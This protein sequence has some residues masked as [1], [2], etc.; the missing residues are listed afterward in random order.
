MIRI[1]SLITLVIVLIIH[2]LTPDWI[3]TDFVVLGDWLA[4]FILLINTVIA[5]FSADI[6]KPKHILL[7]DILSF[8]FVVTVVRQGEE[9]STISFRIFRILNLDSFF[10]K[11]Y[12]GTIEIFNLISLL[13]LLIAEVI[14][15]IKAVRHYFKNPSAAGQEGGSL[16]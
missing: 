6:I 5:F 4:I 8:F 10:L 14:I 13:I 12:A 2:F 7:T 11:E 3:L 9:S 16:L 1:F 15:I